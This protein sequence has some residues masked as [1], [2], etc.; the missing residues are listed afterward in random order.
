MR[1]LPSL[2]KGAGLRIQSRRGPG[3]QIP[4]PAFKKD[5]DFLI[6]KNYMGLNFF[7]S[8]NYH[9]FMIIKKK[10]GFENYNE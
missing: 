7:M 5:M 1:E 9:K 10:T 4:L 6:I 3:V 2:V 8:S